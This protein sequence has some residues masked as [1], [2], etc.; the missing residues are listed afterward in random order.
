MLTVKG[1]Y[2]SVQKQ[3]YLVIRKI[4]KGNEDKALTLNLEYSELDHLIHM[5]GY[6]QST[7]KVS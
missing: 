5:L 3:L 4:C 1:H 2:I 7:F 6:R